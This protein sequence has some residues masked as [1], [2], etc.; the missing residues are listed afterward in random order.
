MHGLK[1]SWIRVFE[2]VQFLLRFNDRVLTYPETSIYI[3][4][5]AVYNVEIY[6]YIYIYIYTCTYVYVHIYIYI[7]IYIHTYIAFV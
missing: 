3:R 6:I 2:P 7:Y 5:I 1:Y 4:D